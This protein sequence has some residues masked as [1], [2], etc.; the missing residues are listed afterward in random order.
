V[1]EGCPPY[2]RSPPRRAWA[3]DA[4]TVNVNTPDAAGIAEVVGILID[5]I[6]DLDEQRIER[7]R[8][9]EPPAAD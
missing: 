1:P 2:A 9:G 3:I 4:A 8:Q 7:L 6:E 5:R